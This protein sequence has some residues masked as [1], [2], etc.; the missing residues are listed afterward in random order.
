MRIERAGVVYPGS[1]EIKEREQI[2]GLRVV[3]S[4]ANG[5][6]RGLLKLPDGLELPATARLLV[7]I[8]RTEDPTVNNSPVPKQMLAAN[9]L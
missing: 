6:I 4:Q 9:S 7:S 1:I 3:V 2:T 8:R 5:K